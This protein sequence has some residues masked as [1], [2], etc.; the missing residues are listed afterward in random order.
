MSAAKGTGKLRIVRTGS[1]LRIYRVNDCGGVAV[2]DRAAALSA[3]YVI[4]PAQVI[5]SP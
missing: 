1:T 4:A 5:T 2:V 3:T